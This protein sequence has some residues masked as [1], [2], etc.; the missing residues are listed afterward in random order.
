M[1][2]T[3]AV[4]VNSIIK[5]KEKY[6]T[7]N[8]FTLPAIYPEFVQRNFEN[9]NIVNSVIKCNNIDFEGSGTTVKCLISF[10]NDL[11]DTIV[12]EVGNDYDLEVFYSL[13]FLDR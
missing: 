7:Q 8:G 10:L 5:F 12:Y 13:D 11:K 4:V 3:D 1:I 9:T 6:L 2:S